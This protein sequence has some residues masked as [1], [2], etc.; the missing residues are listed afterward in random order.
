VTV[1]L[2]PVAL[3][4]RDVGRLRRLHE[5]GHIELDVRPYLPEPELI[6]LMTR[7]WAWVLP[8]QFGTHSG[9]AELGRDL[10]TAIIAPDCGCY[11][12]QNPDILTY[13]NTEAGGLDQ[14][15]LRSAVHTAVTRARP[16]PALRAERLAER[17]L[18]QATYEALYERTRADR[19]AAL[20]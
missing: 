2:H 19:A 17:D 10:G 1:L 20:M 14:E 15:S 5:Q 13:R 16:R 6:A 18:V 12:A 11:A 8:Y 9:W 3:E 4:H 7:A